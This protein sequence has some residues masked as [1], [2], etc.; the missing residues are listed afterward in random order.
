MARQAMAKPGASATFTV[1]DALRIQF[2]MFV[3]KPQ[4]LQQGIAFQTAPN[5]ANCP[6]T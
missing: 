4:H 3:S 5:T 6:P 1:T 2:N